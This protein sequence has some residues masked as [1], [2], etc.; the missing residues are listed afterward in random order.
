MAGALAWGARALPLSQRTQLAGGLVLYAAVV[1]AATA[2]GT[3]ATLALLVAAA[4]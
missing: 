2:T 1:L 3:A 4:R